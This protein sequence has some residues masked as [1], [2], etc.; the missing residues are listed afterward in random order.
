[1]DAIKEQMAVASEISQ[2]ISGPITTDNI[3]EDELQ[4]ELN[5]LEQEVL[6]DRLKGAER[7]PVHTPAT[8]VKER[9]QPGKLFSVS[10][11]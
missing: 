11:S 3:D 7:A 8:P 1:M 2:A 9:T 5:E 10:A 6:D 4:D